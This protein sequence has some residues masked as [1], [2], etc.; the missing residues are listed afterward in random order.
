[1]TLYIH[2]NNRILIL[3]FFFFFFLGPHL[4]HMEVPKR[5]VETELQ[6][7]TYAPSQQ[8][9]IRASSVTYTTAWGNAGS[10]LSDARDRTLILMDV[11]SLSHNGNALEFLILKCFCLFFYFVISFASVLRAK[12]P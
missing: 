8:C 2:V 5:G 10:L 7:P 6:L 9:R 12:Y 11:F 3:S 1:M 4:W